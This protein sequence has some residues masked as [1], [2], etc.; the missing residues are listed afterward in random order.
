M[1]SLNIA[2]VIG[3]IVVGACL[4]SCICGV[5]LALAAHYAAKFD[6]DRLWIRCAVVFAVLLALLDTATTCSWAYQV[7]TVDEVAAGGEWLADK[8][9]AMPTS[10]YIG[11]FTILCCQHFFIYRLY[12]VSGCCWYLVLPCSLCS[13]GGAGVGF[14]MASFLAMK[15]TMKGVD[16]IGASLLWYLNW[17]PRATLGVTP[18][19]TIR[20]IASSAAR[21]NVFSSILQLATCILYSRY[22]HTLYWFYLSPLVGKAHIASFLAT[23]NSRRGGVGGTF[24]DDNASSSHIQGRGSRRSI[25]GGVVAG[26][27]G[28]G[29]GGSRQARS[30]ISVH[31]DVTI[32]TDCARQ[33][34]QEEDNSTTVS[35]EQGIP[36]KAYELEAYN[37]EA[38]K[39]HFD[40]QRGVEDVEKGSPP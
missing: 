31:Q 33:L 40:G 39:V 19:K 28:S 23:L 25:G 24:D 8:M 3:P 37:L 34:D 22:N 1:A 9:G 16:V 21:A 10:I 17:G 36:L 14:Y 20:D 27:A 4:G 30:G 26:G 32:A 11:S 35:T 5:V 29:G 13:L 38:Y 15:Q 2:V 18:T 12:A 7:G 6:E